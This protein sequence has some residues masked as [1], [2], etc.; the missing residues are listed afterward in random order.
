MAMKLG[1]YL[2]ETYFGSFVVEAGG[3]VA[4]VALAVRA[5]R[6]DGD[7]PKLH[8]IHKVSLLS[9]SRVLR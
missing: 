3:M 5:I 7:K 6:E 8:H 2:V 9:A 4:A 1:V